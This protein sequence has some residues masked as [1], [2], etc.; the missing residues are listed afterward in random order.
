V[1]EIGR[2]GDRARGYREAADILKTL[3]ELS[4]VNARTTIQCTVAGVL[5]GRGR[6]LVLV[7]KLVFQVVWGYADGQ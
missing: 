4:D 6:G 3:F 5:G 2:N 1:E 7:L